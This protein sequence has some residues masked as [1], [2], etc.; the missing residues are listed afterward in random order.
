MTVRQRVALPMDI[1]RRDDT[2]DLRDLHL[3]SIYKTEWRAIVYH[4][5]VT[6]ESDW[7]FGP[8]WRE[9]SR[10]TENIFEILF[11]E[12]E[13]FR[14]NILLISMKYPIELREMRARIVT[15]PIRRIPRRDIWIIRDLYDSYISSPGYYGYLSYTHNL[16][17]IENL[18]QTLPS[19]YDVMN[20]KIGC[21]ESHVWTNNPAD[22]K[23]VFI[24]NEYTGDIVIDE[25]PES[26]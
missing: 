26:S 12:Y 4:C 16:R 9:Y 20:Y 17:V 14:D 13:Q 25:V 6:R 23:R 3:K 7:L 2:P 11:L 24:P 10:S 5:H 8:H 18:I 1:R 15:W 21:I 22:R 19:P